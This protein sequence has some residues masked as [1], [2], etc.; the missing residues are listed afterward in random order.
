MPN[1]S[2]VCLS[3]CKCIGSFAYS[4][5]NLAVIQQ[6]NHNIKDKFSNMIIKT[7]APLQHLDRISHAIF[8]P[9]RLAHAHLYVSPQ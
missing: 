3:A 6:G 7:F 9:T 5:C 8:L 1:A 2:Y 4:M